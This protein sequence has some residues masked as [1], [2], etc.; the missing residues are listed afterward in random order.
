M[1]EGVAAVPDHTD[2]LSR[3]VAKKAARSRIEEEIPND[4]DLLAG[5]EVTIVNDAVAIHK[6]RKKELEA[7]FQTSDWEAVLTRCPVH[8]AP[9]LD[10]ISTALG[11][12]SIK[13]C[14][15]A[16]RHLLSTDD[17]TLVFVRKLLGNLFDLLDGRRPEP[18]AS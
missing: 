14:E 10:K 15:K 3:K 7:A 11:F 18:S 1:V 13:D 2:R 12:R 16:V 8:E 17:C 9:A 4:D 5:H 6:A